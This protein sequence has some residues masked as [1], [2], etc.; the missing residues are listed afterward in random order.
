MFDQEPAAPVA[1]PPATAGAHQHP[2]AFELV[3][4]ERELQI[5]FLQRRIDVRHFWFPGPL[6][7][8]HHD[9]GAVAFRD[10][11]FECAVLDWMIL[12]VHR[13]SLRLWIKRWSFGNG[14]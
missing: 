11:A 1:A 10:H 2:R 7:P 6:I 8:E 4:V 3:A 12:D 5:P 14:P 9:S 13:E